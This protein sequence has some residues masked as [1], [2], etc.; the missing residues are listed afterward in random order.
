M[1]LMTTSS[2]LL[3]LYVYKGRK[4]YLRTVYVMFV[5][6]YFYSMKFLYMYID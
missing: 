6:F 3:D 1:S 4:D 5:S 2:T